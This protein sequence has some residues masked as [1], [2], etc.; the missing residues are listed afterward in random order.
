[1]RRKKEK[2]EPDGQ[3]GFSIP[4][5]F[6]D[7]A[8]IPMDGGLTVETIPGILLAAREEPLKQANRP[9]LKLF[10]DLGIGS[11]GVHEILVKGGYFD[12]ETDL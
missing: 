5:A 8:G 1:M 10:S 7:A 3:G 2:I 12:G 11:G 9:Y 4:Q 6:L